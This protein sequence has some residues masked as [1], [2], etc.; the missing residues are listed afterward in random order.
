MAY[1]PSNGANA[2]VSADWDVDSLTDSRHNAGAGYGDGVSVS[3]W[4]DEVGAGDGYFMGQTGPTYRPTFN[5]SDSDYNDHS[6]L[7]CVTDGFNGPSDLK[8]WSTDGFTILHVGEHDVTGDGGYAGKR[9][10]SSEQSYNWRTNQA[11]IYGNST[12]AFTTWTVTIETPQISVFRVR[13]STATDGLQVFEDGVEAGSASTSSITDIDMSAAVQQVCAA[14]KTQTGKTARIVFWDGALTDVEMAAEVAAADAEYL[15][16][17]TAT[18]Q[19]ISI[20]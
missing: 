18:G 2:N 7:T 17:V 9:D 14:E 11:V 19:F 10:G 4:Y 15:N 12:L 20:T 5:L 13:F 16:P 1:T 3:G 8:L 6:T